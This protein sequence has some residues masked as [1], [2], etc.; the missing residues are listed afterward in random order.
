MVPSLDLAR[1]SRQQAL[2]LL[3]LRVAEVTLRLGDVGQENHEPDLGPEVALDLHV[4]DLVLQCHRN[5]GLVEP[6][7]PWVS[8]GFGSSVA[9]GYVELR[10]AQE[11]VVGQRRQ[12]RREPK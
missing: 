3:E 6:R 2:V 1:H 10:K 7:D 11:D 9:H 12:M 8:K 4:L 5:Q